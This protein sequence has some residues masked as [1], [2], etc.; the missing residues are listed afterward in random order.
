V[1]EDRLR[2]DFTHVGK[3]PQ[4]ALEKAEK[5]INDEILKNIPLEVHHLPQE[6]AKR[7]GAIC[8]FGEK[9]GDVVRVVEIPGFSHE[10]CGG[11]HCR[12][13]GDIGF[14]QIVSEGAVASGVRRIEAITGEKAYQRAKENEMTLLHLSTLLKTS[15]D[16]VTESLQSL[17][18]KVKQVERLQQNW[19]K[20]AAGNFVE[21]WIQG[22][23]TVGSVWL[24]ARAIAE[25]DPGTLRSLWDRI[26]VKFKRGIAVL[27]SVKEGK[28]L[29]VIG[30]T[31]DLVKEGWD[32]SQLIKTAADWVGGSGGGKKD[33]AQAGGKKPERVEK[34]IAALKEEINRFKKP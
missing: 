17:L 7:R 3:V 6:E 23:E 19:N 10:F 5:I 34:A 16:N 8:F 29:L 28:L 21:A 24:V 12:A 4:E 20:E 14:L 18:Q 30:V 26:K 22:A 13:T 2:F 33:L 32:A 9:Y 31:H 1:A 11:T 27:W 25:A 15:P